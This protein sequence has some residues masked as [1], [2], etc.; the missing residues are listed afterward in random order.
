MEIYG[1]RE[2]VNTVVHNSKIYKVFW[3]HGN[4]RIWYSEANTGKSG[5]SNIGNLN[6]KLKSDAISVFKNYIESLRS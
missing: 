6:C 5:I 1:E 2:F 4:G 3:E